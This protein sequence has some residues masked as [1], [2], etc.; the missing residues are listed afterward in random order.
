MMIQKVQ[1]ARNYVVDNNFMLNHSLI[2]DKNWNYK[3]FVDLKKQI[4]EVEC[5]GKKIWS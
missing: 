4:K 2:V 5:K 3:E 1:I